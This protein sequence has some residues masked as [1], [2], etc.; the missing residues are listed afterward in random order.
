M[1]GG[2]WLSLAPATALTPGGWGPALDGSVDVRVE[3]GVWSAGVLTIVPVTGRRIAGAEG[4]A[5]VSTFVAGVFGEVGLHR[6]PWQMNAG[7]G[8]GAAIA[9]M[10]GTARAG[11]ASSDETVV[12]AAPFTRLSCRLE[13]GHGWRVFAGAMLG[14]AAPRVSVQFIDREVAT[15][16][17]P[18]FFVGAI[19]VDTALLTWGRSR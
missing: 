12:V 16:G 18:F 19:G 3:H 14:T 1:P 2:I 10:N 15:W 7:L 6:A 4:D 11:Y 5:Q 17:R 9:R 13:V 8:L